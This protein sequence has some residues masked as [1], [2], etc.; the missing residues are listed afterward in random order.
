MPSAQIQPSQA[1]SDPVL[2]LQESLR[3]CRRHPALLALLLRLSPAEGIPNPLRQAM[4]AG[5]PTSAGMLLSVVQRLAEEQYLTPEQERR[6][7]IDAMD[8]AALV[9]PDL[10][11]AWLLSVDAAAKAGRMAMKQA[12]KVITRRGHDSTDALQWVRGGCKAGALRGWVGL[13][14][15]ACRLGV[16]E[17]DIGLRILRAPGA[18][19][20]FLDSSQFRENRAGMRELLEGYV[21]AAG[22]GD[23]DHAEL[24]DLLREVAAALS[25]LWQRAR[26]H[27]DAHEHLASFMDAAFTAAVRKTLSP[28]DYLTLIAPRERTVP[29]LTSLCEPLR[30]EGLKVYLKRLVIASA[31]G[32][33][34]VESLRALLL[35][36]S[37]CRRADIAGVSATAKQRLLETV[38]HLLDCQSIDTAEAARLSQEIAEA[39]RDVKAARSTGTTGM[40]RA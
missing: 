35:A 22:Q 15:R 34:P 32:V 27:A 26:S 25:P 16:I 23:I 40:T 28:D 18:D 3:E 17:R 10:F 1:A 37:D 36:R 30:Q 39:I 12:F 2:L 19:T 11:D 5:D 14:S 9:H 20:S 13:V 24:M 29:L 21:D 38:D 31:G 33:L 6:L 7:L 4:S 8:D